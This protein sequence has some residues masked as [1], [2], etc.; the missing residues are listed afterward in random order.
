VDGTT[1]LLVDSKKG[2]KGN[3]DVKEK[4]CSVLS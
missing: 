2:K 1:K 3:V 4:S